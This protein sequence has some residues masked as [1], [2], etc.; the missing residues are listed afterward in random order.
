V[1]HCT[2]RRSERGTPASAIHVVSV[3]FTYC[4][5]Y[6]TGL[7]EVFRGNEHECQR[8]WAAIDQ[9]YVEEHRVNRNEPL[10]V[11]LVGLDEWEA[12]LRHLEAST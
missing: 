10:H 6:G 9:V 11:G 2:R 3:Q 1:S 4:G 5:G 8:V 12:L 7:Y